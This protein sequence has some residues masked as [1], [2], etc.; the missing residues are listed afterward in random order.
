MNKQK[1]VDKQTCRVILLHKP[2]IDNPEIS[3]C[4][5]DGMAMETDISTTT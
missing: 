4:V 1:V 5:V 2:Q 3:W